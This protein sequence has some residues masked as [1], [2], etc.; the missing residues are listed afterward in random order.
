[1]VDAPDD[2]WFHILVPHLLQTNLFCFIQY[3]VL[4]KF[5]VIKI[6]TVYDPKLVIVNH[7]QKNIQLSSPSDRASDAH[8]HEYKMR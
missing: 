2:D 4:F 8:M 7:R 1:M 6:I 5:Y 3:I